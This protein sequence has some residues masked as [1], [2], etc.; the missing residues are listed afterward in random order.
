MS[1]PLQVKSRGQKDLADDGKRDWDSEI[2]DTLNDEYS[3]WKNPK[4]THMIPEELH[5]QGNDGE[6]AE[7]TVFN[8]LKAFG[9]RRQEPMFVVHSYKFRERIAEVKSGFRDI[10]SKL[11]K[12]GEHDFAIIHR[13]AGFIFFQVKAALKTAKAYNKAQKQLEKDC[14]SM[15]V[16]LG[17]VGL[18]KATISNSDIE[19]LFSSFPGFVVMPN[20]PRPDS[21]ASTYSDGIFQ[22]DCASVGDF[23]QWWDRNI[24]PLCDEN[25]ALYKAVKE[26]LFIL[27]IK[28]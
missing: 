5:R 9:E 20:C 4:T 21:S 22:K 15:K 7:K 18:Q 6:K 8:L 12:I 3:D 14:V 19:K 2:V 1:Y 24:G 16:F 27:L 17:E 26:D 23:S 10:S 11:W 25:D 13:K 28:R